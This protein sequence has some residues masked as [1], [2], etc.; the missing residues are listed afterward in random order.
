M[1]WRATKGS[2]EYISPGSIL[3]GAG[4][5]GGT[6]PMRDPQALF[7]LALGLQAPWFVR[8]VR[9]SPTEQRFDLQLGFD[10]GSA[11]ACPK[12]KHPGAKPHDTR[13]RT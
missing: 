7:A 12:C 5:N 3:S 10:R 6:I 11:F 1:G 9:F 8:D 13:E 4:V 2:V